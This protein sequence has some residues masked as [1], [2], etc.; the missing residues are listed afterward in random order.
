MT[1][2]PSFTFR[3]LFRKSLRQRR[4]L[5][6]WFPGCHVFWIKRRSRIGLKFG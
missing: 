6:R 4:L 5:F 1:S 3:K 2:Y